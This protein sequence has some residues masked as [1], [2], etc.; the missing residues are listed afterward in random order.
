MQRSEYVVD[1]LTQTAQ[2]YANYANCTDQKRTR[3]LSTHWLNVELHSAHWYE[4]FPN[5]LPFIH[6]QSDQLHRYT[7]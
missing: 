5:I 3:F 1:H 4:Q 6:V 7:L 2:N